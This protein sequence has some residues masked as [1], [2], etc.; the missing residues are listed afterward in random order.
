[1][2]VFFSPMYEYKILKKKPIFISRSFQSDLRIILKRIR[3]VLS[4]KNEIRVF[5]KAR[6]TTCRTLTSVDVPSLVT[7][8]VHEK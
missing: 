8:S 3:K 1:M 5:Y 2:N 7:S 4:K 6:A